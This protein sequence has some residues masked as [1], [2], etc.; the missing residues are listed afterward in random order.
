MPNVTRGGKVAGLMNYLVGPGRSN[1]HTDQR[2]IAGSDVVTFGL[3]VGRALDPHDAFEIAALLDEPRRAF[4]TDVSV[5]VYATDPDSGERLRDENGRPIRVG[6][7]DGHVWHCSLSLAAGEGKVSDAQW[8]RIATAFV[9]KMGFVDPDGAKSSRW[10][11]VHHGASKAGNDHIH[12]VVQLVREDGT[13]ASVHNDMHRAQKAA[14]ELEK[15]FGLTQLDTSAGRGLAGHKRAEAERAKKAGRPFVDSAELRRRM[16][17]ALATA[18]DLPDYLNILERMGVRASGRPGPGGT[19]GGYRVTLG[20]GVGEGDAVWRSPSKLDSLLS[21]PRVVR[22]FAGA[23]QAQ[24]ESALLG[25]PVARDTS[26][27]GRVS[28]DAMPIG[29]ADRLEREGVSSEF[30]AGVYARVSLSV[31]KSTPGPL[32]SLSDY[33]SRATVP[34]GTSMADAGYMMRLNRRFGSRRQEQGW[35]AVLRQANRLARVM[36]SGA[37]SR[38]QPTAAARATVV[39]AQAERIVELE[40]ARLSSTA[41]AHVAHPV[42]RPTTR[43]TEEGLDR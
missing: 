38:D 30:L 39:L 7:R 20:S 11:A 33:V 40:A 15:E 1:E 23:G 24:A 37:Y 42:R 26:R 22:R 25:M 10:V 31:E 3:G 19:F 14:R 6:S 36:V 5:P 28:L 4:G 29:L 21:W 16:H 13:K 35:L 18:Q 27:R 12:I 2:L 34:S 43:R 8:Q 32:A 9:D 17:A 41:T